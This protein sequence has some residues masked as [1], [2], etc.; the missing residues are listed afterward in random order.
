MD[1]STVP[2]APDA[3]ERFLANVAFSGEFLMARSPV[4]RA[5]Q[6]LTSALEGAG[7]PYAIVGGMALGEFGYVRVTEDVDVLLTRTGLDDFKRRH[8][9]RGWIERFQGSRG[10]RDTENGVAIDVVLTGDYPGDGKPKP[11]AFPDP[12]IVAERGVHVRLLPLDRLVELKLASGISAPHRL[13]DLADVIE[14]IRVQA[15]Q[16]NFADR[17]DPSVRAKFDELWQAAQVRDPE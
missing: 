10:M 4:H 13:R 14:L 11:V 6:K 1:D 8:L 3:E 17:L 15:L 12:E 5:L 16:R 2:L 9:G 7:I